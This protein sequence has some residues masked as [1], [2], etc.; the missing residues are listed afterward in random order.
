MRTTVDLDDDTTAAIDDL[1]RN[2]GLGLSE[3]V[4]TLIRRGLVARPERIEFRQETH[5]LAL[6][7]D[8][9]NIADALDT[10]DGPAA[11]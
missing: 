4:N 5:D 8:V 2:A 1:R 9:S 3:A 7:L 10:L 6:R 11:H